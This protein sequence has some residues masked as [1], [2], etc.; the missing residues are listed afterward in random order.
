MMQLTIN[1]RPVELE[2]G[3]QMPLLWQL[4]NEL[5]LPGTKFGCGGAAFGAC[6]VNAYGRKAIKSAASKLMSKK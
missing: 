1:D 4:C 6:T 5:N 3:L 2:A